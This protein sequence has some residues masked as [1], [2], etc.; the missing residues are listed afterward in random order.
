MTNDSPRTPSTPRSATLVNYLH[1]AVA[2]PLIY[3]Y[4]VLMGT[5]SLALSLRDA[6][7][8][9][10][11]W[12][13]STW[14][15]MIAR[16][17]GARVTV[18][19]AEHL[20]EGESYVFLSTHQSYM[21]IPV[22]LGYLPAQLRI[23]AKREVFMIPFLGWHMRRGGHISINRGSTE[24]AVASLRRAATEIR[25][26]LSVFLFPEGTRTRD[27]S[28]QP[29]KKGGFRFALQTRLPVVPVTIKGTRQL[30]PRD[31][32]IFRPGP[33]HMHLGPPLTTADLTDSDLPALM[34]H[35]RGAMLTHFSEAMNDE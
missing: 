17:V 33:V 4:T 21:D 8:R 3:L 9:R 16:T 27:G 10:Q 12:C 23:A 7:G 20:R 5:L 11:H 30:L 34:Q 13:A 22:M 31:S 2:I 26:G 15:R 29:F 6:E 19:G 28:L 24:E 25:P 35:V 1:S 32:I 14:S 18:H